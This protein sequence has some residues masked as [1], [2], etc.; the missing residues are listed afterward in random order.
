[1]LVAHRRAG[2]DQLGL[3]L[4]AIASQERVGLYWHVFPTER[5]NRGGV[6]LGMDTD[7]GR[8]FV[9]QAFPHALRRKTREHT[10]E[11]EFANGSLWKCLGSDNYNA[12]RGGNPLGVVFSEYA[13]ADPESWTSI[14]AP[15]LREND[16]WAAFI[17]TP[18]GPNHLHELYKIARGN[19]EVWHVEYLTVED[20]GILTAAD[21]E[22]ARI[23]DGLTDV[24]VRREFYCDWHSIYS[25]TYYAK[26]LD[27]LKQQNRARPIEYDP[28]R[29]VFAA[30]DLGFSDELVVLMFQRNGTAHNLIG[31]RA[32]QFT[33]F[34][35]A[36]ADLT[37]AF[38][39]SIEKHLLP[40]DT[41]SR[42]MQG[43]VIE[44]F[45]KFGTEVSIV[46]RA[47]TTKGIE[48][49]RELFP[50]LWIDNAVRAWSPA[51][52]NARFL[53]AI[54]GYRAA[55]TKHGVYSRTPVHSWESHY[56]DALRYYALACAV[57]ETTKTKW[58][59]APDYRNSDRAIV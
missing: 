49:V 57:G 8:R 13:F 37:Q 25:G 34:E 38:P 23:E 39:W 18:N 31:S 40:H 26:E 46:E 47:D 33:K 59:P 6:W 52:N 58:G 20:T 41:A 44:M 27:L 32:Y 2:K 50:S 45:E 51:G 24:D 48:V 22:A 29:P 12:L 21:M 7:S 28:A 11:V 56:M 1:M 17:S 36:L 53:E 55:S 3:N 19:P 54:G 4:A 35:D 14:V 15:I 10:M 43:L 42:T 30:W 16:G 9:D 5:A